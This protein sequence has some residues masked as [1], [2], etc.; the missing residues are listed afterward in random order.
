M[1]I[2][3]EHKLPDDK[4]LVPGVIDQAAISSSIPRWW[5]NGLCAMPESSGA[6]G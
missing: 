4:I 2:L 5:R 3:D 6:I 1:G